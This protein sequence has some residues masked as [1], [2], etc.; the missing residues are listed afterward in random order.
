VPADAIVFEAPASDP[1]GTFASFVGSFAA[2]LDD[3]EDPGKAFR[4][5]IEADGWAVSAGD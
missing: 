2:A 4:S 1:D 5:T 3:G